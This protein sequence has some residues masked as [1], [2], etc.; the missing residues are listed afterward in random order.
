MKA[1]KI[2]F[3]V[4]FVPTAILAGNCFHYRIIYYLQTCDIHI[5]F[6]KGCKIDLE[7]RSGDFPPFILDSFG[8]IKYPVGSKT[9]TF[10]KACIC[11]IFFHF[12]KSTLQ[13]NLGND[14]LLSLFCHGT[15]KKPNYIMDA[16]LKNPTRLYLACKNSQFFNGNLLLS[17]RTISEISCKQIHEPE[18]IRETESDCS[19]GFSADGRMNGKEKI[20]LVKVGWRFDEKYFEQVD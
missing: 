1:F 17:T 2:Y 8:Y 18:I 13:A 4:V 15:D 9:L 14:E 12:L 20:T 16:N 19:K 10:G 7:Q 3:F 5:S 6:L 11:S